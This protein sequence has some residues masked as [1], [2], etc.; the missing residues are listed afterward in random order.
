MRSD[1]VLGNG[2]AGSPKGEH[3]KSR[4]ILAT[5][6]IIGGALA[7]NFAPKSFVEYTVVLDEHITLK[8]GSVRT[9]ETQT[10]A[11]R[12]DGTRV[13]VS[14]RQLKYGKIRSRRYSR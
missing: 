8:D 9:L 6:T 11:Q 4:T 3:V 2:C 13:E 1:S 10:F 14:E 7:Q 12:A 5:A